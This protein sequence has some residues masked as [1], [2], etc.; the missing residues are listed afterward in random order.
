MERR[1]KAY[2]SEN[3]NIRARKCY[4]YLINNHVINLFSVYGLG[5]GR[6]NVRSCV[7]KFGNGN[8]HLCAPNA[9]HLTTIENILVVAIVDIS[10][11]TLFC[12]VPQKTTKATALLAIA[13]V[14]RINDRLETDYLSI[15]ADTAFENN[16][17]YI[18]S[19][20]K[21]AM[22]NRNDVA[23]HR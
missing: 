1:N 18:H 13:F 4:M 20:R 5:S 2:Y 23:A 3:G 15:I 21:I 22:L 17:H 10:M 11:V 7:Y 12:Y 19:R 8:A 6:S 16:T 9:K 14:E